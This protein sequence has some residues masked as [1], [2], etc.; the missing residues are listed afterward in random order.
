MKHQKKKAQAMTQSTVQEPLLVKTSQNDDVL[1]NRLDQLERSVTIGPEV[2]IDGAVFGLSVAVEAPSKIARAVYATDSVRLKPAKGDIHLKSS[3]AAGKE[4]S[5]EPGAGRVFIQ[6][7][8]N[9]AEVSLRGAIVRG[10]I[11]GDVVT[12]ENCVVLGT[13]NAAKTLRIEHS[14]VLTASGGRVTFGPGCSLILPYAQA[15][16]LELEAPVALSTTLGDGEALT[17]KKKD[18]K[19]VGEREHLTA[20]PRI[21][22]LSGIQKQLTN[23][24]HLLL[25]ATHGS[26]LDVSPADLAL[27]RD[28]VPEALRPV[29]DQRMV[30]RESRGEVN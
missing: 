28:Q 3:V 4:V 29:V 13:V 14:S 15:T 10:S 2:E 17:L 23:V 27:D 5:T 25:L 9:A 11:Y 19:K 1:P 16:T 12:L 18:I 7:D 21:S 8:V 6:G 26:S 24:G 30:D 22:D 20:G